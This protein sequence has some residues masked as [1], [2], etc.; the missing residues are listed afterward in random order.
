MNTARTAV[1]AVLICSP[2]YAADLSLYSNPCEPVLNAEAARVESE[3]V[4]A[5]EKWRSDVKAKLDS[6][7]LTNNQRIA[8]ERV[9]AAIAAQSNE[10]M[11]KVLSLSSIYRALALLPVVDAAT[12]A[13]T[14]EMQEL[15]DQVISGYKDILQSLL[16]GV[17]T[18]TDWG[19]LGLPPE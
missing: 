14:G 19:K 6:M 11:V 7:G 15:S 17:D 5:R 2:T 3:L 12:C 16:A 13:K 18:A 1:I 4:E 10:D 8:G 9:L